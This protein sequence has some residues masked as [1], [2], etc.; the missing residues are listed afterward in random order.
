M[1]RHFRQ[2]FTLI[3]LLVVIAIIAV[4][5]G[6]LLPAV[7]KVREAAAR[8]S[9]SNN[10]KQIALA[11]HSCHD[12]RGVFTP[13]GTHLGATSSANATFTTVVLRETEWSWAYIL[14]PFLEQTVIHSHGNSP[15]VMRSPVKAYYCPTRRSAQAVNGQAKIDYAGNAGTNANGTNGVIVRT[16]YGQVNF[17][18]I[19]DGTTNTVLFAEKQLNRAMFGSSYDDNESYCTP[20]WNGDWEVYRWGLA[21]PAADRNVSGDLTPSHAFGSAHTTGL[22]VAFCDGSVRF[23]RYGLEGI[24]WQ[25]LC[26]RNDGQVLNSSAW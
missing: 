20:G 2:G 8:M 21:T 16:G 1:K 3:E 6:L 25:R 7:Q 23:I 4:L 13:G 18:S 22:N 17:L 5:I 24:V 12:Q 9:C 14:L 15:L 11:E 10:L 26:I 19:T